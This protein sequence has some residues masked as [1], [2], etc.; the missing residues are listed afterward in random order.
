MFQI[1][2]E[3]PFSKASYP[4]EL[5]HTC[6]STLDAWT[7]NT[8]DQYFSIYHPSETRKVYKGSEKQHMCWA[9]GHHVKAQCCLNPE[10]VNQVSPS[11][12]YSESTS[13]SSPK[14][15]SDYL[16]LRTPCKSLST[17][18][19]IHT[20]NLHSISTYLV[21]A[22]HARIQ[23]SF[24]I[25]TELQFISPGKSTLVLSLK[26]RYV[27]IVQM[28]S[29]CRSLIQS[30]FTKEPEWMASFSCLQTFSWTLES[31]SSPTKLS[32]KR[33]P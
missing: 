13:S 1:L 2:S 3:S 5:P 8:L 26:L 15:T 25:R 21:P 14:T 16:S 32:G 4:D 19:R 12:S 28:D 33:M 6:T 10:V 24:F 29:E 27:R 9:P 18:R 30:I 31:L 7:C 23:S 20:V 22:F 17:C 11:S